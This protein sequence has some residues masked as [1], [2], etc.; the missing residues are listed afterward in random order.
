[1]TWRPLP[2]RREE[3]DPKPL[4]QSLDRLAKRVG[5]P[6]T[7]ALTTVFVH[8]EEAVGAAIADHATPLSLHGTTLVVGV[9]ESGWATQLRYLSADVLARL[10]A[11]AGRPVAE[12]LEVRV[13]RP[14]RRGF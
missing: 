1:M 11:A 10:E 13:S 8:W 4:R 3:V 9:D 14:K 12:R 6:E 7:S 5:A 2:P